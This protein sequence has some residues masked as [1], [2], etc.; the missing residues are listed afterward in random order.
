MLYN[1]L[2]IYNLTIDDDENLGV[3]KI[4]LV[5][6]P[7][8]EEDFLLFDKQEQRMK[9]SVSDED[10]HIVSGIAMVADR[11]IYRRDASGREYYVTFSKETIRKIVQRYAK[12]QYAFN[13]SIDHQI[14]VQGCYV[15]ESFIIDKERGICPAEFADV[16]DGSWYVSVKIEN[17][18]V[19]DA[20][21]NGGDLNGFSVEVD[22]IPE[23]FSK[24][25]E[26]EPHKESNVNWMLDVL[27]G[28][29]KNEK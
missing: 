10:R 22:S 2:P 21:K 27:R 12:H 14:D 4:S 1:N 8:V 7:A 16:E 5:E 19:W 24:S 9:F 18:A 15:F 28:S 25:D 20:L 23:E 13:I 11:P 6:Y 29:I 26:P 3:F 17:E